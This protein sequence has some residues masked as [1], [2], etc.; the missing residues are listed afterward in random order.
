MLGHRGK[1]RKVETS[2]EDPIF[3]QQLLALRLAVILCHAR[4]DP[5]LAGMTLESHLST[6]KRFALSVRSGWAEA[7]P[8]ST[9]LLREEVIA[10]QK[11]GWNLLLNGI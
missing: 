1:L 5:D 4:R 8:Q 10:W 3:A 11:M 6:A 7:W 9:H 2:L